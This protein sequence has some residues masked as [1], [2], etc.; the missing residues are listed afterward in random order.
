LILRDGESAW[1]RRFVFGWKAR[2]EEKVGTMKKV[3]DLAAAD[4]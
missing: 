3:V 1:R 2:D 4:G